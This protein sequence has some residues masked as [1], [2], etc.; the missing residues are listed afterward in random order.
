[1]QEHGCTTV[2]LHVI[3]IAVGDPDSLQ[4]YVA[5]C[6]VATLYAL[7]HRR[8]CA[9]AQDETQHLRT[10]ILFQECGLPYLALT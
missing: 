4:H 5:A 10:E 2:L 1:M 9:E 6:C 7:L 8:W 3:Q